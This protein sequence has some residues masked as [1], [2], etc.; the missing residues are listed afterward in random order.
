[1]RARFRSQVG[2]T[3]QVA[4]LTLLPTVLLGFVL[5]NVIERQ[6]ASQ[7]VTDASQS[8]R[9]IANI[10]IQPRLTPAEIRHGLSPAQIGELDEQLRA[11]EASENLAR[12]KIWNTA[13]TV[14]Y[15]DDH[16][17][18]DR[19]LPPSE[20]L[21]QALQG[22]PG[23]AEVI[24]P[25]RGGETASEVGLGR[26]VEVYVPLRFA[27]HGPP[28]GAFE[29]Y[30]SYAP[31]AS[32]VAADKR[33]IALVVAIGLALLW[34]I[35]F[36]IVAR[37]ARRLR[38]QADENYALARFDPLTGLPNRMLFHERLDRAL[39]HVRSRG[40]SL[41]VLMIDL[42]GFK[43]INNT[44][45]YA[46]GD[47]VLRETARRLG[48]TLGESALVARLGGDEYAVLCPRSDGVAGALRTAAALQGSL[49]RP[50]VAAE[51]ALN[52]EANIGIAVI[53]DPRE[54]LD[55]LLQRAD[56]ALSRAKAQHGRIEVYSPER[57]RFDASRLVLLG[58]ARQAIERDEFELHYQPK[59]D[60]HR[61]TVCGVEALVR[62]RHPERGLL[63]PP[64][65]IPIV[66]RTALI[67]PLTL[68]VIDKALAQMVRWRERDI[69][70]DV[71]INLSARNLVDLDLPG[72]V[73]AA[74]H[75]H[76]IA[77][78]RL[79]LEVTESATM[80]DSGRAIETLSSLRE[81]GA[82]ISIDDF[83]TGNASIG[84]L[85]RL[86]A[87]E[88]KIDR[89]FVAGICEDER[90]RAIVQ[91]IVDLARNL[92][93]RIVAEGIET[94]PVLERIAALG[95]DVAQGYLFSRPLPAEQ[96]TAW[97]ASDRFARSAR[98]RQPSRA[99]R[100]RTALS[101]TGPPGRAR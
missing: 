52:V 41:A 21:E 92:E 72:Q 86:P 65:F 90:S 12:I 89:T 94:E 64:T 46:T 22:R 85:S 42:E 33:T 61:R 28:A 71:A 48:R 63:T 6:V 11:R 59:V 93:L 96:L 69:E 68:A 67:G 8:A 77:A 75:R 100:S 55:Q 84:Y 10:G 25:E 51:T 39:R 1:V 78:E 32:A 37:A 27:E 97:L 30:L 17:L 54:D 31:I 15:S 95:C 98:G 66:E 101:P 73:A 44:L 80:L 34:A 35:L 83:G 23:D 26:L 16:R 5:T 43:E 9:L 81:T 14:V 45:G 79:T 40:E 4:L 74:L 18:I 56:A 70:L 91:S 29:I 13:H 58:Q 19:R 49:E 53:E 60:L 99:A 36:P 24:T 20:D 47:E 87:N 7:S 82:C 88:L 50:M 38:R 76:D 57:D 2:L 62:W 3:Q